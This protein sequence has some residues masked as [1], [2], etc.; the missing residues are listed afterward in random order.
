MENDK[1]YD[2]WKTEFR[3]NGVHHTYSGAKSCTCG[4]NGIV[5]LCNVGDARGMSM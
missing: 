4:G 5:N 1:D 2:Q 3:Q